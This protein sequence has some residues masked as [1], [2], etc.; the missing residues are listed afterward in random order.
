MPFSG[1][2]WWV[3]RLSRS[4]ERF[5]TGS[6]GNTGD[7]KAE[8]DKAEYERRKLTDFYF[9]S[10]PGLQYVH[11]DRPRTATQ[12]KSVSSWKTS[13]RKTG[14]Q[15]LQQTGTNPGCGLPLLGR[16]VQSHTRQQL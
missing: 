12:N 15:N 14:S 11:I 7:D 9:L 3:G 13:Q 5:Q 1:G 6:A 2:T 8:N 4:A 16:G 10:L